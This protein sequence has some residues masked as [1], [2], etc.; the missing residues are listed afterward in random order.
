MIV[1]FH[2]CVVADQ[3]ILCAGRDP[4]DSD[5]AWIKKADAVILPQ[6]CRK[7]LYEMAAANCPHVFPD[8]SARFAFPG[9]IG[10][11]SLFQQFH[12]PFPKTESFS[13]LDAFNSYGAPSGSIINFDF[14]FVFKFDWG[15]ESDNVVLINS[16]DQLAK[17]F[18][19]AAESEKT[20]Q[21]GFLIQQYIP[22]T[23]RSLRV[24]VIGQK[25]I[26]YWRVQPDKKKFS[27]GVS[28]GA[29]IDKD[30]D[31]ELRQAGIEM[32]DRLCDHTNINLAGFDIIFSESTGNPGYFLEINYFFGRTGLGGSEKFYEMLTDEINAWLM[33]IGL[34]SSVDVP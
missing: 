24:A 13:S 3:N 11:A 12:A 7:T 2:P 22:S 18:R 31:P 20:G 17:A 19:Q 28:K 29:I 30:S 9:K 6:G 10:Q 34:T 21:F 1:S 23:N 26:A 33:R 27:T 15:G 4:D 5:L 8:Y 16:K 32:A 14:P 25:R